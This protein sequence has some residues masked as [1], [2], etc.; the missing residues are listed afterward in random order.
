MT[1]FKGGGFFFKILCLLLPAWVSAFFLSISLRVKRFFFL[2]RIPS[3]IIF[4]SM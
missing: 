4:S 2:D 1:H 3:K